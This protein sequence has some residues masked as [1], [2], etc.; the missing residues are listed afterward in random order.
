[1]G[2]ADS[3]ELSRFTD[4]IELFEVFYDQI[5]PCMPITNGISQKLGW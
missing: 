4:L 3:L 1:M 2:I 5:I